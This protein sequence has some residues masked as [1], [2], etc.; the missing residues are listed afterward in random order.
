[1]LEAGASGYVGGLWPLSDGG[2]ADFAVHFYQLVINALETG[3]VS[4]A[5]ALR[6]TRGLFFEKGDPTFLAYVYYGDPTST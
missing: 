5:D 4:V 1:V 3:S 6:E 2:A